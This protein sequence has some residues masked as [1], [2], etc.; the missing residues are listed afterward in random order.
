M[1]PF[2][3]ATLA[4]SLQEPPAD[5]V[6][7]FLGVLFL[8]FGALYVV[9]G[10]GLWT[11]KPLGRTLQIVVACIGLLALPVGTILSALI[12]YYMFRPGILVLFS[13]KTPAEHTPAERVEIA[14]VTRASGAMVAIIVIVVAV[15]AV[16]TRGV[17]AAIAVPGLLRARMAGNEAMAIGSMRGIGS[18]RQLTFRCLVV[19]RRGSR[20]WVYRVAAGRKSS[21]PE[22]TQD[23]SVKS[24]YR[25]TLEGA[26][27]AAGPAD[28]NGTPT[29]M[30][31]YATAT[32][33]QPFITGTRAFAASAAG[34]VFVDPSPAPPSREATL[35]GTAMEVR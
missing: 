11:L 34:T 9:T 15:G 1:V 29:E 14:T 6:A 27:A 25:I 26:G 8:G 17:I 2:G 5:N 20:R 28:C 32:P 31:D 21:S 22:L 16:A 3:I 4:V 24:G 30:D 13:G 23:P 18:A 19:M 35:N 7:V 10:I 12:L 33:A